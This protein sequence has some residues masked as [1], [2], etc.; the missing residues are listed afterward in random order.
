VVEI[1]VLL[2][3]CAVILQLFETERC[4][5]EQA[6]VEAQ[7]TEELGTNADMYE[8]VGKQVKDFFK[9]VG[10][11]TASERALRC[12]CEILLSRCLA[13]TLARSRAAAAAAA[14]VE[15]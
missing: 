11:N 6:T 2:A 7:A 4:R 10:W 3:G 15:D 5:S 14:A 8:K 12:R 13:R 9:R 1:E